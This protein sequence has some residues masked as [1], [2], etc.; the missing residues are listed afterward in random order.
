MQCVVVPAMRVGT[1]L[2]LLVAFAAEMGCG[3]KSAPLPPELR[4]ADTTRD[5]QVVQDETI[6]RLLWS[7]PQMT[8]A[9][10]PLSDLES[11]EV[12]R[13]EM[14]LAQEPVTG[15]TAKDRKDRWNLLEGRGEVIS[16]LED[17]GLDLATQGPNLKFE[18]DLD[19][20]LS[21][22]A[23]DEIGDTVVWY[24]V[25]S[26]CCRGRLSEFSNIVRLIPRPA[27]PPPEGLEVVAERD[28]P[29]L[30]W[31]PGEGMRVQV[32]RSGDE[33]RWEVVSPSPLMEGTWIDSGAA[34]ETTW[35][36]R[37]RSVNLGAGGTVVRMGVPGP[38]IRLD[39]PDLYPPDLP[40]DL[41]CL[42]EGGRVRLRWQAA[43]GATG[44]TVQRKTDATE[45]V[46]LAE[47][48]AEVSF[49]DEA[50]PV[51][52]VTYIVRAVDDA[53]N[54]SP[55]SRCRTIVEVP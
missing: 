7:Y 6:A 32:E 42:P 2:V 48:I 14:P 23:E 15:T 53:A 38:S 45:P 34:Q 52:K 10:G 18:D 50:P 13:A 54:S 27:S 40:V 4:V 19:G 20:W 30:Q 39:F 35:F 29:H 26:V 33:K 11:V 12:W 43:D 5:L 1:V 47:A 21:A 3:R 46:V 22:A 37:L 16:R 41:V 31:T 17:D 28:G 49:L 44:Y 25:R 8:T 51:G 55:S 36:Y 24:A 9:G